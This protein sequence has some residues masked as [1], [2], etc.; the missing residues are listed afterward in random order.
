[1]ALTPSPTARV[2]QALELL[3]NRS[4]G[5]TAT[6]LGERLGV[7]E[8]AARRYVEILREA[9]V[10]VESSRGRYGG[11]RLARGARLPPVVFSEQE[12][13]ALVM[14]VLDGHPAAA[15]DGEDQ[16]ASALTKV[17]RALPER[18]A[19]QAGALREY[20]FATADRSAAHAD[21]AIASALISAV[22]TGRRISISYRSPRGEPWEGEVDP[23]AVVARHGRWYLLCLSHRSAEIR[24]YRLDRIATVTQLETRF[25]P[26]G[27]LDPVA[28]LEEHLGSGWPHPVRIVFDAPLEQVA[29]W[30]RPTMGRLQASGDRCVL[31]G[32]TNNPQMY[33]QE[34]LATIPFDFHVDQGDELREA[35]SALARRLTVAV[36]P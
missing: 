28:T 19:Q 20:A 8:R 21:P 10:S 24:T 11:Y 2:L 33:A 25:E 14:A 9:G 31:T 12:A 6:E 16:V 29:S 22:A 17:I 1:M 27:G 18:I 4:G 34:W 13:I 23:W 26:P 15:D 5:V 35:V 36:A 30:V 32:S 3:Q 7:S